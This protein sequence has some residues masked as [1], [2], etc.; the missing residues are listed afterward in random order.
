MLLSLW[1]CGPDDTFGPDDTL[2]PD[3]ATEPVNNLDPVIPCSEEGCK[4]LNPYSVIAAPNRESIELTFGQT[5]IIDGFGKTCLPDSLEF[6]ISE[7]NDDFESVA[8]VDPNSESYVI[9][10]LEQGKEYFVKMINL[11]C[12]LDPQESPVLSVTT[13]EIK[14]PIIVGDSWPSS[15]VEF[16]DFRLSPDGDNFMYRDRS[17]NWYITSFSS[18]MIGSKIAVDAFNGQ[19]HPTRVQEFAFVQNVLLNIQENVQGWFSKSLKTFDVNSKNEVVLHEVPESH[20]YWIHELHYSLD[21]T[22]IY[23]VSNKDNGSTSEQEWRKY[24]NLWKLD[25]QS[26]QMENLSNFL[27]IGFDYHDFIEDPKQQ[28]NF[29]MTGGIEKT[30]VYYYDTRDKSL[31]PFL[32]TDHHEDH[33]T[34]SP[35]GDHLVFTS[36]KSGR[37]EIWSYNIETKQFKQITNQKDYRPSYRWH[38]LNW[39]SDNQFMTAI[40]QDDELKFAVFKI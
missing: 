15:E 14:Q 22:A 11:H 9:D 39:I 34:I 18:E 7:N 28:G 38:H 12:E 4:I 35:L 33:I 17:N 3:D 1:S 21:G 30:D 26:G 8:V 16:E 32:I 25:L 23:F 36:D 19:W 40:I 37:K 6:L 29:Y 10:D 31:Q 24:D 5:F 2:V 20:E 13:G 27:P